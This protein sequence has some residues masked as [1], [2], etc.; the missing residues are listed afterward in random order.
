MSHDPLQPLILPSPTTPVRGASDPHRGT[1][2]DVRPASA[3][4]ASEPGGPSTTSGDGTD[5]TMRVAVAA[6]TTRVQELSAGHSG[7]LMLL[8]VGIAGANSEFNPAT[9]AFAASYERKSTADPFGIEEQFHMNRAR[10]ASEGFTIPD[11]EEF[12]FS[13]DEK[14]GA[15]SRRPGFERLLA[16]VL[17]GAAPFARVYVKDRTRWG[18]WEDVRMHQHFEVVLELHRV[19]LRY[20][21]ERAVNYAAGA[22]EDTISAALLGLLSSM[23]A[24]QERRQ[25]IDRTQGSIRH[26]ILMGFYPGSMAPFGTVRKLAKKLNVHEML[27]PVSTTE[28][29][30]IRR[31]DCNYRLCWAEDGTKECIA[32]IFT[33]F[34]AGEP[35]GRLA[36]WL[37]DDGPP[38]PIAKQLDARRAHPRPGRP[39]RRRKLAPPQERWTRD[40]LRNILANPIYAGTL[41]WGRKR[42]L[43]GAAPVPADRA[44]LDKHSP[45]CI[46]QFLADPPVAPELWNAVQRRLMANAEEQ[47]RN[48]ATASQFLLSGHLKCADCGA[49]IY[50]FVKRDR[51]T[52]RRYYRHQAIENPMSPRFAC[53]HRQRYMPAPVLDDAVRALL[54]Q[55]LAAPQ[56]HAMAQREVARHLAERSSQRELQHQARL[57][58]ELEAARD[59]ARSAAR[60]A[61]EAKSPTSREIH[62]AEVERL[63]TVQE[64][65]HRQL[66]AMDRETTRRQTLR[67]VL[68]TNALQHLHLPAHF[69]ALPLGAQRETLRVLLDTIQ[70]DFAAPGLDIRV[71]VIPSDGGAPGTEGHR[72]NEHRMPPALSHTTA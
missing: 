1:G 67:R 5:D 70:L 12:R 58:A 20:C 31:P 56:L 24:S 33:R 54:E 7:V 45:L 6:P 71:R 61:S 52:E 40:A 57:I 32:E 62:N 44:H 22:T 50:G 34:D 64:Q 25:I 35:L 72:A 9:G 21:D 38:C 29:G 39:S 16:T 18:R 60:N 65:A 51:A 2:N 3:A 30:L 49:P 41:V 36:K 14:S 53:P 66:V 17:S 59:A 69:R 11:S 27:H 42:L 13:D 19:H 46:D 47:H 23:R 28:Y 26:R 8:R 63:A 4:P 37:N 10:A 15:T 43:A 68:E 55:V 48:H